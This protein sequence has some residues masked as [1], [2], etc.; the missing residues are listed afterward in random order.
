MTDKSLGNTVGSVVRDCVIG[1][2]QDN[3]ITAV[4]VFSDRGLVSRQV[5]ATTN[6][7][8]NRF[9]IETKAFGID[10]DSVQARVFGQGEILGVQYLSEPVVKS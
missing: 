9:A 8:L 4:T 6:P 3:K 2:G 7:G 1:E 10:G 5:N